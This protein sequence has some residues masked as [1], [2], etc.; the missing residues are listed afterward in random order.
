MA[1]PG[2]PITSAKVLNYAKFSRDYDEVHSAVKRESSAKIATMLKWEKWQKDYDIEGM[3]E[4]YQDEGIF[5]LIEE[6]RLINGRL[7]DRTR[8]WTK[9]KNSIEALNG[10][11]SAD[12]TFRIPGAI[13]MEE[14]KG[15]KADLE[16]IK[17]WKD[18]LPALEE[19]MDGVEAAQWEFARKLTKIYCT[20]HQK[21]LALGGGD[22]NVVN[23]EE[24]DAFE[25]YEYPVG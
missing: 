19:K 1:G 2:R 11:W 25:D 17:A 10:K 12:K 6:A 8:N 5:D 16:K 13:Q 20:V 15:E 4:A 9:A 21:V 22:P 3:Y 24:R 7:H 14:A 18:Q 23:A